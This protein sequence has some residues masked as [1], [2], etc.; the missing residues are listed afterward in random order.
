MFDKFSNAVA[1]PLIWRQL[2]KSGKSVLR[3]SCSSRSKVI[4]E[5]QTGEVISPA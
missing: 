1:I 2:C 5:L 4:M 3:V